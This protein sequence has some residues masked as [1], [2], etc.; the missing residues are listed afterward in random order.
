MEQFCASRLREEQRAVHLEAATHQVVISVGALAVLV[1]AQM[2]EG[3]AARVDGPRAD[4]VRLLRQ[5]LVV[6]VPADLLPVLRPRAGGLA[7]QRPVPQRVT[8][9]DIVVAQAV[10][11][12]HH[13]PRRAQVHAHP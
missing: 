4:R 8:C 2:A 13:G 7:L 3:P 11:R 10:V 1:D 5:G 12:R 9:A 6:V